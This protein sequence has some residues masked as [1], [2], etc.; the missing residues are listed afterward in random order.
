MSETP[1]TSTPSTDRAERRAQQSLDE[2]QKRARAVVAKSTSA[3]E[4]LVPSIVGL[5]DTQAGAIRK[6]VDDLRA[7]VPDVKPKG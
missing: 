4:K 5:D 2:L 7:L 1:I 3:L 6:V